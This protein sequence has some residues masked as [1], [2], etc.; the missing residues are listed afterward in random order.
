MTAPQPAKSRPARIVIEGR[1]ARLEPVGPQHIDDLYA[2]SSDA[3]GPARY[4]WLFDHAPADRAQM[5]AW[6]ARAAASDDPLNFAVIDRST[7][8]AEGRQSLM[9]IVPADGVI[10]IGGVYWG[11]RMARTRIATEA[12]Y[13]FAR[14]IFDELGYRRFEWKCN[15]LN[16]PSK[17]AALRFGFEFEGIFRQ[18]MIQKG[19]NRDTAWFAMLDRD[20]PAL[21]A[22]YERWLDPA[23][24][25]AGGRQRTRL[26]AADP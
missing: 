13:L 6:V 11:P 21:K 12:V 14:Y 19:E 9:R 8:H 2:A 7:G 5:A 10:E 22:R 26:E 17:R 1:Y 3:D 20:W 16:T 24:F 23:N 4:R 15:D 25:D 18:H